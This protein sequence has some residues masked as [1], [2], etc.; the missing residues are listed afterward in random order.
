MIERTIPDLK[1]TFIDEEASLMHLED[2]DGAMFGPK[3]GRLDPDK[4]ANHYL[5]EFLKLGGNAAFNT[6]ADRLLVEPDNPIGIEGEP[7]VWQEEDSQVTGAHLSG[8]ISGNIRA[9]TVVVACG[10]WINQLLEPIGVDGHVK[11]K[12]RQLF[13]IPARGSLEAFLHNPNFNELK[14][15]PF[16][17]L[18]KSGCFVKAIAENREFWVGCDDD[19]GREYINNPSRDLEQDYKVEPSYYS[20]HI[21]PILRNYLP[22]FENANPS[23]MWAGLYSYNTID[24][25]PFVFKERWNDRS[26][27]RQWERDNEGGFTW[28]NRRCCLQTGR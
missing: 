2:V 17:I 7:F 28:E 25:I 8:K 6:S 14:V 10:A 1:T 19:F 24:Y 3:C 22:R 21:H 18:P 23:Q 12:K 20:K 26:R 16:V 13:K 4:L 9:K 5:N 11:A 27:R 15:L